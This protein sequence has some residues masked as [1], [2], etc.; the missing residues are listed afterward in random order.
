[1]VSPD[2]CRHFDSEA[3]LD[4]SSAFQSLQDVKTMQM[5]GKEVVVIDVGYIVNHGCLMLVRGVIRNSNG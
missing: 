2:N 3:S 5:D 1:V 4:L